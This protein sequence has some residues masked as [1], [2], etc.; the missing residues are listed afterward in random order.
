MLK[1]S[2]TKFCQP[3][4]HLEIE[5]EYN[6][7]LAL[8]V[9]VDSFVAYLSAE[10]AKGTEYEAGQTIQVGWAMDRFEKNGDRLVLT[11]PDFEEFPIRFVR[12]VTNTFR[13][14]RL[15]KSVCESIGLED[16]MDFP[17]ILQTGIACVRHEDSVGFAMERTKPEG[18]DSGW[19]V[20]CD[21]PKHD[22]NNPANLRRASLYEL[23]HL[24]PDCIPFFALPEHTFVQREE[25]R[26][27]LFF[28][29][30][31][32]EI[33]GGSFLARLTI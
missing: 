17:N 32:L 1:R 27:E 19:F 7:E 4:G 20:G 23:A 10:V 18:Q 8:G 33:K 29:K 14:L 28:K 22:H 2:R 3:H 9:D 5:L 15:Q 21:D 25:S 31:K 26:I 6:S 12:G 16:Q 13:Q 24:K 11:E 30:E